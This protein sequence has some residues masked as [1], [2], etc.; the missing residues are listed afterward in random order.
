MIDDIIESFNKLKKQNEHTG[1]IPLLAE[2]I[3]GEKLTEK[4][5]KRYLFLLCKPDEDFF[6]EEAR[7][8]I[9]WLYEISNK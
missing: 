8:I 1:N 2:A 4:Q 3:K 6:K 9:R 7:E 5:I